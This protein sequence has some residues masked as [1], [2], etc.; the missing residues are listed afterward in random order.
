[1]PRKKR[2]IRILGLT[3]PD[4]LLDTHLLCATEIPWPGIPARS[5][6]KFH[7]DVDIAGPWDY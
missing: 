5:E 7:R 2:G 1:M 3:G 4:A 6:K